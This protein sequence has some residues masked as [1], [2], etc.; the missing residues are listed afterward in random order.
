MIKVLLVEDSRVAQALMMHV[1]TSDPE[2]QVV[3]VV[4][5]GED[6]LEAVIQH[7]PDIVT[8]DIHM[9][10]MNGFEATRTIM[11]SHPVPIVIVSGSENVKEVAI[12]FRAL[13]AGALA[14]L[15]KPPAV[16]HPHYEATAK[17]LLQI[18]KLMSE[19]KVVR[20]WSRLAAAPSATANN[21]AEVPKSGGEIRLVAIGASTGGPPVLQSI[22]S[23]LPKDFPVPVLVVQHIASGF[24][25][26]FVEWLSASCRMPIRIPVNGESLRAS[27]IY[28]APDNFHL[29]VNA[30]YKI[31]LSA[32]EN[33]NGLRPSVSFLFRSVAQTFGARAVG[34]LLTGMGKDGAEGL[35]LMKEQGA[36]TIVQ[37]EES[38]VIFGMPGEAVKLNAAKYVLPPERI[39]PMLISLTKQI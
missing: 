21:K 13:E 31:A 26:G 16:T 14:I 2:I 27:H 7:H 28:V 30:D 36:I 25:Q 11:E 24:V 39:A 38:S 10:K 12:T 1:L 6:A 22:L 34:V 29:G 5:N 35:R 32:G 33:E 8:M 9:P 20:R 3:G 23:G 4:N 37:D 18:V 17:E 19:V 15:A